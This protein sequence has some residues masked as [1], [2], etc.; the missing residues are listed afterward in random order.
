MHIK[1]LAVKCGKA[2]S[3]DH[4]AYIFALDAM[5]NVGTD[6]TIDDATL[7]QELENAAVAFE[8]VKKVKKDETKLKDFPNWNNQLEAAFKDYKNSEPYAKIK[9]IIEES[10]E[11]NKSSVVFH[12]ANSCPEFWEHTRLTAGI[13]VAVPL[14]KGAQS[15]IQ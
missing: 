10:V 2:L 1:E 3:K 4:E 7:K 12:E 8:P 15:L 6:K 5:I 9:S 14:L 13:N 11:K